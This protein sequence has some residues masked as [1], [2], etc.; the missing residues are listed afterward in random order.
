MSHHILMSASSAK[1]NPSNLTP[2]F[3]LDLDIDEAPLARTLTHFLNGRKGCQQTIPIS[4]T[5]MKT[6]LGDIIPS[7]S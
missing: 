3:K 4:R 7:D 6:K 2:V 5:Q 1:V